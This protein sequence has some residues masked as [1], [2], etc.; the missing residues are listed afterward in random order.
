MKKMMTF[1]A[2]ALIAGSVFAACADVE[3]PE[4]VD[5]AGVY[6]VVMSLKT[7]APKAGVVKSECAE[8]KVCYRVR[9][10]VSIKGFYVNCTLGCD[11]F[12][13]DSELILWSTKTK[14]D[15]TLG[16]GSITWNQFYRF[17]R[18][19]TDLAAD[20]SS[21]GDGLSFSAM[22]FGKFGNHNIAGT[23]MGL[24]SSLSG[25][26]LAS[27]PVDACGAADCTDEDVTDS[28][29]YAC[30]GTEM[31]LD[32]VLAYG[33]WSMKLDLR[34][35]KAMTENINSINAKVPTYVAIGLTGR[36]SPE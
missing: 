8:G 7:T 36:G 25:N 2:M 23:K 27:L 13:D 21:T 31:S 24:P 4:A 3:D 1:A 15:Y 26:V 18:T 6:T 32:S 17:G 16:A 19:S 20:I 28:V 30:D 29:V 5:A 34:G 9:S 10:T 35:S 14:T 12:A 22:G 33:T 11:M